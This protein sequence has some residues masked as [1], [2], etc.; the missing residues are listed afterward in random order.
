MQGLIVSVDFDGNKI[1]TVTKSTVKLNTMYQP[2]S[3]T[4]KE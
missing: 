1:T 2:E 4:P 3:I